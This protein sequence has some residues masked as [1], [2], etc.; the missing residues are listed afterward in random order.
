MT[1]VVQEAAPKV[2]AAAT[3]AVATVATDAKAVGGVISATWAKVKAVAPHVAT[4]G[5]GYVAG[6][7][8][9]G[10]VFAALKHIL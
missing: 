2:E 10:I 3:S 4:A 9:G 8:T 7:F 5:V 6:H 1:D